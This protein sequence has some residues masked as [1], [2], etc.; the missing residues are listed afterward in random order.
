MFI[1]LDKHPPFLSNSGYI[2]HSKGTSNSPQSVKLQAMMTGRVQRGPLA[3]ELTRL[4]PWWT[5]PDWATTDPQLVAAAR[6][7]FERQPTILDDIDPPNLYTLR[8]PRRTG[9][10]TV[11]KQAIVRLCQAGIDPRRICFFA[12][13]ALSSFTDLITLFQTAR[14]LMPDLAEMPRYFLIDEITAIPN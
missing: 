6:A 1:I 3:Q 13:D 4:N 2:L 9:K 8:G 7:P 10:S 5:R 12:A 11:L 14:Q